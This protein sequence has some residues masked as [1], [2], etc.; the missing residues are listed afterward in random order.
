MKMVNNTRLLKF[1]VKVVANPTV[2][3]ERNFQKSYLYDYLSFHNT[4][5]MKKYFVSS[6]N[7]LCVV[8]LF[9]SNICDFMLFFA[10]EMAQ[11]MRKSEN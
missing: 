5:G 2:N 1:S 3:P 11:K 8:C 4:W 7:R 6:S 10:F 9:P